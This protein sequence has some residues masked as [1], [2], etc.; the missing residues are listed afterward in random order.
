MTEP[1]P[2]R[3]AS[4]R[5]RSVPA[6]FPKVAVLLLGAASAAL[7]ILFGFIGMHGLLNFFLRFA[8]A[9]ALAALILAGIEG[10][11]LG[12]RDVEESRK[13]DTDA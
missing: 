6:H 1:G 12:K 5:T 4:D 10:W 9:C 11:Q 13:H 8:G 7:G 3:G 2:A